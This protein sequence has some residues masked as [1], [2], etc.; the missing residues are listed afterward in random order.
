[1]SGFGVLRAVDDPQVLS[2][3]ALDGRLDEAALAL[4]DPLKGLDDHSLA[5]AGGELLPPGDSVLLAV[6][7]VH[8]DDPV[9]R[10][11]KE[12]VVSGAHSSDS[13]HVPRVVFGGVDATFCRKQ[14]E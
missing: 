11:K 2:A 9:R 8:I 1:M 4:G 12:S 13:V 6:R 7:V 3:A 14:V 5:A 10:D